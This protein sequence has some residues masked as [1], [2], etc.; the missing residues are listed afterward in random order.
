MFGIQVEPLLFTEGHEK[1]FLMRLT[2]LS[3]TIKS[4]GLCTVGLCTG[5]MYRAYHDLCS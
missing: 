2:V 3:V 1:I 5:I 4:V